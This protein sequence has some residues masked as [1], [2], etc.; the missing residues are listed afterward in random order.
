MMEQQAY[1]GMQTVD[2]DTSNIRYH[3][4][5]SDNVVLYRKFSRQHG[6]DVRKQ[7]QYNIDDWLNPLSPKFNPD[8]KNAIFHYSARSEAGERF[9]A[10]ISTLE[11]SKAAFK[12][13]HKSQL[14]LDRTFGVCS[15]RL[16][17]FI[18]LAQDNDGKG[19]PIA[20][21]LFL[22][23]TGNCA[24]HAGYNTA[25]LCM[26][27]SSWKLH[28]TESSET[29]ELFSPHVAITDTDTKE[30]GALLDV[31]PNICLLICKFHLRQCWTNH[32][33]AAV[34]AHNEY[35]KDKIKNLLQELEVQFVTTHFAFCLNFDAYRSYIQA[36]CFS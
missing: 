31:W 20:F 3:L 32:R 11:M 23:P 34:K 18:A 14:I 4:L 28:L 12:Y 29:G 25:I 7:P 21:F 26:L 27:I 1:I 5:P 35:W 22:A 24:T 2:P 6:I 10:C 30:R 15:S 17:L 36:H 19:V 8:I 13:A 33:K 16:L 9:E